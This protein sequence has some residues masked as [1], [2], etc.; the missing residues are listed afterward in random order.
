[1]FAPFSFAMANR[2]AD[3]AFEELQRTYPTYPLWIAKG[4]LINLHG[5]LLAEIEKPR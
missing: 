2:S 1:M 3:E 5:R 4:Q